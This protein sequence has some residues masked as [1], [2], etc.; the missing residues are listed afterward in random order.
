MEKESLSTK[1]RNYAIAGACL[2]FALFIEGLAIGISASSRGG[3]GEGEPMNVW[4]ECEGQSANVFIGANSGDLKNV[5]CG[6]LDGE[7][8]AEPEI[9]IGDLSKSSE[10]VCR[11]K[12]SKDVDNSR[13][14]FDVWYN[15]GKV[16][17]EVCN[18][19]QNFGGGVD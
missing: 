4:S 11:F 5:K 12:P 16:R 13:L 2:V 15:N 3:G 6:A 14:R 10:D 7:L 18:N 8:F 9:A 17:R 1:V 19:W